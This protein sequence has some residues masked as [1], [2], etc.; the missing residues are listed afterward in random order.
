MRSFKNYTHNERPRKV[1]FLP[2]KRFHSL[3]VLDVYKIIIKICEF[4]SL[5]I[6]DVYKI[7]IK[8]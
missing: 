2:W 3:R 1:L 4:H 5:H 8:I 7:T 6:L